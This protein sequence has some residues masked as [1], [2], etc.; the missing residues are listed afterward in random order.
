VGCRDVNSVSAKQNIMYV[1]SK[2]V[3]SVVLTLR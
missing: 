1:I 2:S 3:C